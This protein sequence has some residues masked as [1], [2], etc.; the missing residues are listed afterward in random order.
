MPRPARNSRPNLLLRSLGILALASAAG[1]PAWL[2]VNAAEE[3]T[4]PRPPAIHA[5][6]PVVTLPASQA[7]AAPD[8]QAATV[9]AT[10]SA[11]E[12]RK[13]DQ[14]PADPKPD[15]GQ[16]ETAPPPTA[17]TPSNTLRAEAGSVAP[18][19]PAAPGD[20]PDHPLR[21]PLV[22]QPGPPHDAEPSGITEQAPAADPTLEADGAPRADSNPAND[23][24]GA[25]NP[26][27]SRS[28]S[29]VDSIAE[30]IAA[31]VAKPIKFGAQLPKLPTMEVAPVYFHGVQP[32]ATTRGELI[33]QW[34]DATP[35]RRADGSS[36]WLYTV[37]PYPKVT[38]TLTGKIVASITAKLKEPVDSHVLL[39]RLKLKETE[40]L[41]VRDESGELLG[42]AFPEKGLMLSFVPGTQS[43]TQM[44]LE[45]IDPEPF[46][47]RAAL[48]QLWHP[49][50]SLRDLEY[51]LKL[52][53]KCARAYDL[54]AQILLQAGRLA[55]ALQ[56][57]EH[58]AHFDPENSSYTLDRAE[59]LGRMDHRAEALRLTKEVVAQ[60]DLPPA[61]KA[62]AL[63]Q[64]GDLTLAATHDD[65]HAL[66]LHLAAIKAAEPLIS[67]THQ[68]V[69]RQA[70]QVLLDAH[71]GAA[72]DIAWGV[73]Q[74][75]ARVVPKW[76]AQAND[77][78]RDLIEHE[79]AD[80]EIR[81]K[82]A[83][84][85]LFAAAGS[86]GAWDT[87]DWIQ[88]AQ[89]TATTLLETTDDP[90]RR[91]W[92]EWELGLA[93]SN[94]LEFESQHGRNEQTLGDALRALQHLN[95]G[96]TYRQP[97]AEDGYL[98]GRLY[99]QVGVICAVRRKDHATAVTWFEQALPWFDGALPPSVA[100]Q[101]GRT[102][103]ML[104]SMGISFWEIGRR[105]EGL[106]L[107]QRGAD[108]IASAVK[109]RQLSAQALAI[110]Y[111]NLAAMH[112][113]LG[114]AEQARQFAELAESHDVKRR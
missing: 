42:A 106:R 67:D 27:D 85:A 86:R 31:T 75:K 112:R 29:T 83:R 87:A 32:G 35:E 56:A 108:L 88:L 73:W 12:V 101:P 97:T 65:K 11:L 72:N 8:A 78:A 24:A 23:T 76:L 49:Q 110:P 30:K 66:E 64:L 57:A 58:A 51:A 103:D 20:S 62:H 10:D 68:A 114:H 92:L 95:E 99:F 55:D 59:I 7:A 26:G 90:L 89:D 18:R 4:D 61:L 25:E 84:E 36:E 111:G 69:R 77:L 98:V 16:S 81:L 3:K 105:D 2:K 109:S 82:V 96:A 37:P 74:Q 53:S 71:L 33:R 91:K 21:I 45:T 17:A 1:L 28:S 34:G 46:L 107:T 47:S 6:T 44:L 60:A 14:S 15:A 38:V 113:T 48:E 39:D 80:P 70:K 5:V 52:D 104:V 102:G 19:N 100:A 9:T 50:R 54:R 13:V 43:V 79:D 22:I 94:L 63:C 93:L 40:G 41:P